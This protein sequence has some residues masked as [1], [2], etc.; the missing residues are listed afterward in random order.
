M[1]TLA[2]GLNTLAAGLSTFAIESVSRFI[3]K[4]F[5]ALRPIRGCASRL[6][7]GAT[8]YCFYLRRPRLSITVRFHC[9]KSPFIICARASPTNRR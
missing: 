3:V 7:A 5:F 8:P 9:V 4:L 6:R 2:T 1:N